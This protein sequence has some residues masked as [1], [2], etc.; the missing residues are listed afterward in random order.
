ML[1]IHI[2]LWRETSFTL[3][4]PS[5]AVW[6]SGGPCWLQHLFWP[7]T[8]LAS[9]WACA[10]PR[11]GVFFFGCFAAPKKSTRLFVGTPP[12]PLWKRLVVVIFFWDFFF[13]AKKRGPGQHSPTKKTRGKEKACYDFVP[14][15]YGIFFDF[16]ARSIDGFQ[17][18][19]GVWSMLLDL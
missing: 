13:R 2:V 6:L 3:V 7:W 16:D 11:L 1:W 9:A 19:P 12:I 14:D 10:L 5:V 17:V 8:A 4:M 15:F 18:S